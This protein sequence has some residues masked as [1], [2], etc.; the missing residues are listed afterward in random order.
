MAELTGTGR[1]AAGG[2][3]ERRGSGA[4]GH[5]YPDARVRGL[6]GT[7]LVASDLWLLG[8]DDRSGRPLLQSRALGTGLA[9]AVLADLMLAGL[10]GLR[11]DGAVMIT[12]DASGD[13]VA[14]HPVL[15]QVA[16][17]PWP[18]P[19]RL[20]LR[21]LAP[22]MSRDVALRLAEAGYLEQ[23]GSRVPWG[24]G[25]WV[26]VDPDWAFAPMLLVRSALDPARPAA[27]PAAVLAGLAVACGL[28]FR[29]AA[30]QDPAGRSVA[31]AVAGLSPGLREL[32][33][34]TRT[35]VDSAVLSHRT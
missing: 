12:R 7:G 30:Y 11:P 24:R 4:A 27:A 10:V 34:Q 22:A 26:P 2:R 18:Q 5:R 3:H 13:V 9:G 28:G 19:A 31:D 15:R 17:E 29:L 16:A 21:F 32:I 1:L 33:A 23:A 35:V 8:H 6:A 14:R 25:Q 20:W